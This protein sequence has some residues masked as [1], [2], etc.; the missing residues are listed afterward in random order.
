MEFDKNIYGIIMITIDEKI[1]DVFIRMFEKAGK[2]LKLPEIQKILKSWGVNLQ[3]SDV[4]KVL[5]HLEKY[6]V[7]SIST[8]ATGFIT[9]DGYETYFFTPHNYINNLKKRLSSILPDALKNIDFVLKCNDCGSYIFDYTV[10]NCPK[11]GSQNLSFVPKTEILSIIDKID[12][13]D[14]KTLLYIESQY[15]LNGV[16][17]YLLNKDNIS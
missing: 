2:P 16:I 7:I 4:K 5:H 13:T 14:Y 8:P 1:L 3:P 9:K 12:Y 10:T 11:C 15:G 6:R 17:S